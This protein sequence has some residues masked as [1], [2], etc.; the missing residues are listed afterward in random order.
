M[1]ENFTFSI[2][3]C[4]FAA[5]QLCNFARESGDK[6]H[7]RV[8][9][10]A[11]PRSSI[12]L[13]DDLSAPIKTEMACMV[14]GETEGVLVFIVG[15]AID[16]ISFKP[17]KLKFLSGLAQAIYVA[18]FDLDEDDTGN[19]EDDGEGD[20]AETA[21]L[22]AKKFIPRPLTTTSSMLSLHGSEDCSLNLGM[23]VWTPQIQDIAKYCVS[24]I[25]PEEASDYSIGGG[26][27]FDSPSSSP[28]LTMPPKSTSSSSEKSLLAAQGGAIAPEILANLPPTWDPVDA[29]SFPVVEIPAKCTLPDNLTWESFQELSHIA[30]GSNSNIYIGKLSGEKV[31]VKII[32]AEVQLDPI[33]VHEFDVEHGMLSRISHPN[34]IQLKGAGRSPRRFIVLEYLGGGSLNSI[35][36]EHQSKPGITQKLFRRPSFTYANLLSKARDMADAFDYLH[37][38]CHEGAAIIHRGMLILS[39]SCPIL[40]L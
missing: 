5:I 13:Y 1:Q 37:N 9:D 33:A 12:A 39:N 36:Q 17:S 27:S 21:E 22:D 40:I 34:I 3:I 38:K 25:N 4:S 20:E 2:V 29:F 18:A 16:K 6:Y 19:G 15:F 10:D 35:L 8:V 30:D 14:K 23:G 11:V 7:W 32:K 28:M 26:E 24:F 31:V